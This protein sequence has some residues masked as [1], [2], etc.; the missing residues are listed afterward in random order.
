MKEITSHE[1]AY[2]FMSNMVWLRKKYG[3][4]KVKMA[5]LLG[6]GVGSLNKIE[7]GELP[8]RISVDVVF[9][10]HKHFG[11]LPKKQFTK[12]WEC[13]ESEKNIGLFE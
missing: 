11:I 5:K 1:E 6:I 8:P 10:I 12:L 4:S 7:K 3:F 9:N 2:I 13:F